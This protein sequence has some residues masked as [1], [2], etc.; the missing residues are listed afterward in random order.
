M[1]SGSVSHTRHFEL[2]AATEGN[3]SLFNVEGKAGAIGRVC[4][5]CAFLWQSS[6]C[7]KAL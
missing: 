2:Y 3:F 4:A 6:Q 5:F 1:T 7:T